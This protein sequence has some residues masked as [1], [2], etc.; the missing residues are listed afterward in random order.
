[1]T[2]LIY[3]VFIAVALAA[4]DSSPV[5]TGL[6]DATRITIYCGTLIDGLADVPKSRQTVAIVDG[7][8]E[9]VADGAPD[10]DGYIDLSEHTCLPG[11]I[12]THTHIVE[13]A[14]RELNADRGMVEQ[15]LLNL[16]RNSEEALADGAGQRIELLARLNRRGNISIEVIDDGPGIPEDLRRRVFVPFF[17][18][19]RDGSGVG[20]ALSRQVMI[21]HGGSISVADAEPH[22]T[23]F[24]LTF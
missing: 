7:R 10:A 14:D 22:G 13:P 8:I 15:V 20:L 4:C 24:T 23:R 6:S 11:L 18:T 19:K 2:R 16:L 21:A 1:M 17:T 9:S 3:P 5:E 12:D